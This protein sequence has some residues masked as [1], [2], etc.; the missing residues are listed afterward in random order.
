MN[1]KERIDNI[2]KNMANNCYVPNEE[3][4]SVVEKIMSAIGTCE[5]CEH[6]KKDCEL[7][8]FS[9]NDFNLNYCNRYNRSTDKGEKWI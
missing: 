2:I 6:N 4:E 8:N 5:T 7:Q 3:L 1:I 9:W